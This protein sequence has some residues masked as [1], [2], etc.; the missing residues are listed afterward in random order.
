MKTRLLMAAAM[1]AAG[2]IPSFAQSVTGV[3]AKKAPDANESV[4]RTLEALAAAIAKADPQALEKLAKTLG[5]L[6]LTTETGSPLNL[7]VPAGATAAVGE[8]GQPA[9]GARLGF[10]AWKQDDF[11]AGAFFTFDAAPTLNGDVRKAGQ[12]LRDPPNAGTSIFVT[13]N[14]MFT[15]YRCGGFKPV[16]WKTDKVPREP[17]DNSMGDKRDAVI[18]GLS[19]RA[20]ATTTTLQHKPADAEPGDTEE[21]HEAS[22]LHLSTSLLLTSRTFRTD[23]GGEY[24]FGLELGGTA[25]V[26]GG[27][28][29]SH[30]EFLAKPDVFGHDSK[31]FIG[32]DGTFFARLNG[33]QPFVRVTH[34]P[35]RDG[36]HIAGLTGLQASF[37]INVLSTL[38]QTT[39]E[40]DGR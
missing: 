26:V 17:C 34:I 38:F 6:K 31:R 24:Q 15:R 22:I 39:K 37:G 40:A 7:A 27:D 10:Q 3:A 14:R 18:V 21:S 25:R 9:G 28:A 5:D 8:D 32:F 29:A 2:C 19:F 20:G 36:R 11:F 4:I 13:G 16:R 30:P 23:E 35:K 12:F 33:F 1:I